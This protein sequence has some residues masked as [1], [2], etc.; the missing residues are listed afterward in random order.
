MAKVIDGISYPENIVKL[1]KTPTIGDLFREFVEE[2]MAEENTLFI[3]ASEKIDPKKQYPLYI[4]AGSRHE[5]NID[6][7]L[8]D[9]ADELAKKAKWSDPSWKGIYTELRSDVLKLLEQNF[10][11]D[12]YRSPEFRTFHEKAVRKSIKI[13]QKMK[14]ELGIEDD[15]VLIE[16]VM[17]FMSN[18]GKALGLV[19]GMHQKKMTSLDPRAILQVFAKHFKIK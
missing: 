3:E 17:M 18:K 15:G 19:K 4:K 2:K 5:I 9:K 13:P 10:R 16:T 12:F 6:G 14:E 11:D 1:M 8:R 7:K